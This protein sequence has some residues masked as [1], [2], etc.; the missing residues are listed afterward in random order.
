M[1][2]AHRWKVAG[3]VLLLGGL[4]ALAQQPQQIQKELKDFEVKGEWHYNDF[5]SGL[6]EA[7]RTGK[8]LLIVF[9]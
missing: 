3:M 5:A 6:A 4:A 2:S 9:R 8:P 1:L 7:K